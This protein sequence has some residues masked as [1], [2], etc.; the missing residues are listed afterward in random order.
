[1]H[2]RSGFGGAKTADGQAVGVPFIIAKAGRPMVRVVPLD[3]Q[4]A[5][6]GRLGFLAGALV[7]DDFD[8]MGASDIADAFEGKP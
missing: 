5:G 6:S 3:V 8:R 4:A 1:M 2:P 7:P